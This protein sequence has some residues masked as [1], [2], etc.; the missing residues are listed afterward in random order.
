MRWM[1]KTLEWGARVPLKL[2]R[3]VLVTATSALVALSAVAQAVSAPPAAPPL[4]VATFDSGFGG[5]L[6]AKSI[7]VTAASLLQHYDTA[8]TIRHYGDTNMKAA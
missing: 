3:L 8:I 7:E 4:R 2:R 5:Y 6:T 1:D